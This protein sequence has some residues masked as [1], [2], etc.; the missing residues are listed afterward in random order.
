MNELALNQLPKPI[1][2]E[3]DR[4][5]QTIVSVVDNA[6]TAVGE[7]LKSAQEL[8]SKNGYGCFG[9]WLDYIGFNRETA[10][11]YI[12]RFEAIATNCGNQNFEELPDSLI[13]EY[14]KPST[15]PEL[16]EAVENGDVL[17]HK[18]F[19]ELERRLKE[20]EQEAVK[21][22]EAAQ[23]L[24][25]RNDDLMRER[26]TKPEPEIIEVVKEVVKIP[27]DYD[28]AKKEA[29]G[30]KSRY[31]R[32]HQDREKLLDENKVLRDQT[33]DKKYYQGLDVGVMIAYMREFIANMK[34]YEAMKDDL[35]A[36]QGSDEEQ[37]STWI[38]RV[39]DQMT[40][41]EML[42]KNME[43]TIIE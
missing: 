12:K 18:E 7:Q 25:Q 22:K 29:D 15:K 26:Q 10:R 11:R 14:A 6:K 3:L 19:K 42:I 16:K 37:V 8:L 2:D 20:K 17:T 36:L 39:N 40:T 9:E 28:R 43:V 27:D 23:I 31:Q 21:F 38:R 13:Y 32:L 30:W 1:L 5:Q 33:K 34:K 4:R 35:A 24:T 41:M